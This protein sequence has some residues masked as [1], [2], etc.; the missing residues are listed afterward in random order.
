MS[1]TIQERIEVPTE[2]VAPELR[3][4][5]ATKKLFTAVAVFAMVVGAVSVLGGLG[6][7]V[8]TYQ[9]AAA[10]DVTT[11][12][13]AVFAEV[14]VRGPLSMWAQSEIITEHQLESTGGL[15]FAQMPREVPVVDEAGEPVLDE[16]GEPV[17]GPNEAR[18]SWIGATTLTTS[19]G[20]GILAYALS[21]FAV[22]A[23]LVMLALG[24]A[25]LK[26]EKAQVAVH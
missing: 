8:Y 13:D 2:V 3:L 20:L 4:T 18:G 17:M 6:G 9:Q 16:A 19:L 21:A 25:V 10:Q 1:T 22:A 11:P 14:P 7:A 5:L 23:G 26:L 24:F 12:G 15:Y